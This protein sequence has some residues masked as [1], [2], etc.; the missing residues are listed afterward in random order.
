MTEII[1][2]ID[3]SLSMHEIKSDAIGGFNSFLEAQKKRPDATKLTLV[4]F[5]HNYEMIHQGVELQTVNP[6]DG[7]VTFRPAQRHDWMRLGGQL[8]TLQSV[9]HKCLK[10]NVQ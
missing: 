9:S 3:K 4:L 6:L 10:N 8:T 7:T 1:C 5:D 2:I